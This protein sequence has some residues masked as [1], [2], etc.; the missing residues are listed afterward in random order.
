MILVPLLL[1]LVFQETPQDT[2]YRFDVEVRT[3]FVDVFVSRDGR[4]I[5]DLTANDFEILDQGKRQDLEL[6]DPQT[7]F[8]SALLILDTSSSVS[9]PKLDHLR[10]AAHAFVRGLKEK[11]QAGLLMFNHYCHL[12]RDLGTDFDSLHEALD[13]PIR[14][15]FTGLHDAL[16]TGLK[17]V[18][19]SSGRPMVVLFTD[20]DDTA[21]WLSEEEILDVA[22]ESEAIVHIIGIRSSDKLSPKD[23]PGNQSTARI[24]D[25]LN[26]VAR[27][28]GGRVWYADSSANLEEVFL[29]VLEE[30]ETR[31]LLSYQLQ[32]SPEPGWHELEVKIKRKSGTSLRARPGYMVFTEHH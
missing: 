22:K 20:G 25:F 3:V 27:T 8:S 26:N 7:F 15:G 18:G 14:G 30:M 32:G 28:T 16:Y 1:G 23:A 13:R 31:Y 9:G 19:E 17:L 21:S 5:T 12:R 11:D 4:P 6:V 2:V 29:K 10:S 24:D